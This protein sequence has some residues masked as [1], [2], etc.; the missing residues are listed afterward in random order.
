MEGERAQQF[1]RWRMLRG[2]D[3][4]GGVAAVGKGNI[5]KGERTRARD[6]SGIHAEEL[7]IGGQGAAAGRVSGMTTLTRFTLAT[8]RAASPRCR[9]VPLSSSRIPAAASR[10]LRL[11]ISQGHAHCFYSSLAFIFLLEDTKQNERISRQLPSGLL[12]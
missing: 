7:S 10:Y 2:S 9:L 1:V 4:G 11:S 8:S 3:V 12:E 5:L 6:V